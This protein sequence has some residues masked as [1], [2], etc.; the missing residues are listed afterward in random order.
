MLSKQNLI[1]KH[2]HF[3]RNRTEKLTEWYHLE[4][5]LGISYIRSISSLHISH[6]LATFCG[7]S[8]RVQVG[9]CGK[10]HN[11]VYSFKVQKN[12]LV[13]EVSC[14]MYMV[15]QESECLL[16]ASIWE[17]KESA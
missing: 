3:L 7:Y 9:Q 5:G 16:R 6:F 10:K 13:V 11:Q 14:K 2:V 15:S 8:S 1:I 12:I 4:E 17:G